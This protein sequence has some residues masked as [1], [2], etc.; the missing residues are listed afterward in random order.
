MVALVARFC[1]GT[2]PAGSTIQQEWRREAAP[3]A[4]RMPCVGPQT[5]T[6]A[7]GPLRTVLR[8]MP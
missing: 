1:Q 8:Q 5:E 7:E 6:E 2:A 3:R 4:D